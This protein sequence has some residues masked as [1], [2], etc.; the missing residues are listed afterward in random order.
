MNLQE[1]EGAVSGMSE[2]FKV[3]EVTLVVNFQGLPCERIVDL[4]K[5]LKPSGGKFK[6]VKNTLAKRALKG[7][8]SSGISEFFKGPTAIIWSDVDPVGPTKV[9]VDFAKANEK[10]VVKAGVVD[11]AV[12]SP[13]DVEALAAMP[14]REQLLAKLL[15]MLNAPATRLLQTI[16]APA[17]QLV[18]TLAAWRDEIE[19]K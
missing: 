5:Q 8:D 13:K 12:L 3:A 11:G 2:A 1:K 19:K 9:V 14:S 4:R 6:V 17:A 10:L 7:T 16:N 18:R 15:A